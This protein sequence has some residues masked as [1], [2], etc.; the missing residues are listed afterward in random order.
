MRYLLRQ[1]PYSREVAWH[2]LACARDSQRATRS[3]GR[4]TRGALPCGE[5]R[6]ES[7]FFSLS[8]NCLAQEEEAAIGE[9]CRDFQDERRYSRPGGTRWS[10]AELDRRELNKR[11]LILSP[12]ARTVGPSCEV[13]LAERGDAAGRGL[14]STLAGA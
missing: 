13:A 9:R 12:R 5:T 14:S 10:V 8:E 3:A 6:T 2:Q 11:R 4:P 7:S 1:G